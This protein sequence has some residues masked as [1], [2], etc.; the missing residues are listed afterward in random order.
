MTVLYLYVVCANV[1]SSET[2]ERWWGRRFV[3]V[4]EY[5]IVLRFVMVSYLFFSLN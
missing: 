3:L 1:Y 4:F 2:E 5:N